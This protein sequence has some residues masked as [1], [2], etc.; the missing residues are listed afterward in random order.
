MKQAVTYEMDYYIFEQEI[1]LS[2]QELKTCKTETSETVDSN[3]SDTRNL[4]NII[5]P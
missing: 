3:K 2:Y 5:D 4:G 1:M